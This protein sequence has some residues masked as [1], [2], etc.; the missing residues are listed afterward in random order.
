MAL[1]STRLNDKKVMPMGMPVEREGFSPTVTEVRVMV[2]PQNPKPELSEE[3]GPDEPQTENLYE[4]TMAVLLVGDNF[5][6]E[7]EAFG[8]A[9]L[10]LGSQMIF[11]FAFMDAGILLY[12]VKNTAPWRDTI[13]LN[14]MY[15]HSLVYKM[16]EAKPEEKVRAH[17]HAWTRPFTSWPP[18]NQPRL[19]PPRLTWRGGLWTS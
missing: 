6:L 7:V 3:V 5:W 11:A 2:K 15:P 10:L 8:L 14:T 16:N 19:R 1:G 18:P 12:S 4:Y 9:L 17:E 13:D